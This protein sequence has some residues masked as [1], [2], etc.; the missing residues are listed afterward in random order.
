MNLERQLTR[1]K[2]VSVVGGNRQGIQHVIDSFIPKTVVAFLALDYH[3][4]EPGGQILI[5]LGPN[6]QMS[7]LVLQR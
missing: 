1:Y 7:L 4:G 5:C 6:I 2:T 3:K